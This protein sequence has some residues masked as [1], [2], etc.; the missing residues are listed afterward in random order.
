MHSVTWL[1]NSSFSFS[2]ST[3]CSCIFVNV[4]NSCALMSAPCLF[5]IRSKNSWRTSS[6][7]PIMFFIS[8]LASAIV[9]VITSC[10]NVLRSSS[11]PYFL[12]HLSTVVCAIGGSKDPSLFN[13][14][15][16]SLVLKPFKYNL[17]AACLSASVYFLFNLP[18]A[19]P[20][21]P[22]YVHPYCVPDLIRIGALILL[23]Y[24]IKLIP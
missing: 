16:T 8:S 12:A 1:I 23:A 17:N 13:S 22:L 9:S 3:H 2:L 21:T 5:R 11:Q 18:L 7:S 20:F 6:T 19:I 15:A 24:L 10:S 4:A 14:L